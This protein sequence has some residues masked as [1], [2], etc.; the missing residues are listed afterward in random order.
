MQK[1]LLGVVLL[2][3]ANTLFAQDAALVT[4]QSRHSF[5]ET[6]DRLEKGIK[7]SGI[8]TLFL[9]YDHA[10]NAQA[11]GERL[12]PAQLF[13]FGNPKSGTAFLAE[14]P[15][16]GLDL[17]NRAL[18]WEDSAGKVWVTYND[19]RQLLSR[20]GIKRS[21]DQLRIAEERRKAIFDRVVD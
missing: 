13:V 20:H 3:V 21:E 19:F 4:R 12:N 2:F 16:L 11:V 9:R 7:A 15:T 10:A 14:A 17:P 18:V 1:T 6:A 8:F 5:A